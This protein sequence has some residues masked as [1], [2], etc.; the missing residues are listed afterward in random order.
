MS[1]VIEPGEL[2]GVYLVRLVGPVTRTQIVGIHDQILALGVNANFAGVI[3]DARQVALDTSD[4]LA[5]EMWEDSLNALPDHVS[6]AYIAPPEFATRRKPM[7]SDLIA[8]YK[9]RVGIFEAYD[10]AESWVH[11]Q[12]SPGM[13]A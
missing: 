3:M 12:V 9:K 4:S 7:V 2:D 13:H 1:V 10:A 6:L 5:K 11:A 8:E